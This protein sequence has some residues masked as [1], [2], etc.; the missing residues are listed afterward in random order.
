MLKQFTI[1]FSRTINLGNF[2]SARVEASVTHEVPAEMTREQ[3]DKILE[4][5]QK[6]IRELMELTWKNQMKGK[7][8]GEPTGT[9][10]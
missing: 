6:E 8:N 1:G 4:A 5:A 3:V 9:K 2:E 10:R 7:I